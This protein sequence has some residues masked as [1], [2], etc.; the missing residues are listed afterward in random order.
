MSKAAG[1]EKRS[2]MREGCPLHPTG[3]EDLAAERARGEAG[4]EQRTWLQRGRGG[5]LDE[6]RGLGCREGE[7]GGWT[8]A[9]DLAAERARREAGRGQV[10]S[11]AGGRGA[12]AQNI[13][14][15]QEWLEVC[16]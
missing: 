14:Q 9:E 10:G 11:G 15:R 12:C 6:G 7:A 3:A 13:R 1:E 8:R 5:R 16:V 2:H 4:R